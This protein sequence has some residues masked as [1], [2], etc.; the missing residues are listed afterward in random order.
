MLRARSDEAKAK[1]L[2]VILD[3]AAE[4][5]DAAGTDLTLDQVAVTA[6]LTRTTLYGYAAT[7]EELLI[8]LTGRELDAWFAQ[9][10]PMLRRC[11]TSVGVARALTDTLLASPRLAPL[12]A[13][14]GTVFE[15]NISAD[16]AIGWKQS[17]HDHLVHTGSVIDLATRSRAGAGARLLLHVYASLTG[18][19]SVAFPPPIAAKAIADAGLT[20]LVINHEAELRLA[21]TALAATLLQPAQ[22]KSAP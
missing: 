5:F 7:R 21:I 18:L 15:R 8:L 20:G 2:A 14:C 22:R 1:R 9:V 6:G 3:A 13:L 10:T 17:L 11:R 19:H 4:W 12:L 16:A